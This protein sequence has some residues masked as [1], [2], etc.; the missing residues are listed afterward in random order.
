M[1][2]FDGLIRKD[3]RLFYRLAIAGIFILLL[4]EL[5]LLVYLNNLPRHTGQIDVKKFK[6]QIENATK[7]GYTVV[8][9]GQAIDVKKSEINYWIQEYTRAY[10]NEKEL[11]LDQNKIRGYLELL[12][13]STNKEAVDA[14]FQFINNKAE[15]FIPASPGRILEIDRSLANI[16]TSILAGQSRADLVTKIIEPEITLEKINSLGINTLIASGESNFSGSS[17]ARIK[18]IKTASA[19]FNGLILRPGQ[20]LSFNDTLGSVDEAT[21]YEKEKVI[22]DHALIY[23]IGGGVCQVSTTIFRA[24]INAG[25]PILERKNHAFAVQYYYPQGMDATIYPGI[26][27]LRLK[28]DTPSHIIFQ[29]RIIGTKIIFEIYGSGDGRKVLVENPVKYDEHSDGS[30]KTYFIRKVTSADGSL[31]EDRFDSYYRSPSL[32]PLE[33]NPLE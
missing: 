25:F 21:G 27:N 33:K 1:K 24:A 32:Y 28:N 17:S 15:I 7:N 19:K 12:A 10:T 6:A 8:L 4:G 11:R 30:F 2:F 9:E 26:V 23:E 5:S 3:L 18:N 14:R 13:I 20:E 22:K 31:K 29:S 16:T